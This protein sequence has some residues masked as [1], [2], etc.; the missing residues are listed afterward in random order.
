VFATALVLF[1]RAATPQNS[2]LGLRFFPGF[3]SQNWFSPDLTIMKSGESHLWPVPLAV[4]RTRSGAKV[5]LPSA[6]LPVMLG[7]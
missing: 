2:H 3:N 1:Q 7:S 5:V 6:C 4:N